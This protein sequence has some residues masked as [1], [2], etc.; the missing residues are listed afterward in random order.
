MR[1]SNEKIKNKISDYAIPFIPVLTT[2]VCMIIFWDSYYD[3]ND[4]TAIR[5]I[6][7]GTFSGTPSPMAVYVEY[8]LALLI[9][10]MYRIIP[11][12]PWFGMLEQTMLFGSM[13]LC[14]YSVSYKEKTKIGKIVYSILTTLFFDAFLLSGIVYIQYTTVAGILAAT[15]A[16]AFYFLEDKKEGKCFIKASIPCIV[17]EILAFCLRPNMMLIEIP[18]I[19]VAYLLKWIKGAKDEG[20]KCFAGKILFKYFV[21]LI[22]TVGLLIVTIVVNKIAYSSS[23]WKEYLEFNDNR[24]T[25]FDFQGYFPAYEDHKE[26]YDSIGW[27]EVDAQ[28]LLDYNIAIDDRINNDSLKKIVEYNE[29]EMG[30][31]YFKKDFVSALRDYKYKF[32]HQSE[33]KYAHVIIA[34]YVIAVVVGILTKDY[35]SMIATMGLFAAR[36]MGWMY[37]LMRERFPDRV[38]VPLCF[39]EAI[40]LFAFIICSLK[41]KESKTVNW[42]VAIII[43]AVSV[44]I[45]VNDI[46]K[47]REEKDKRENLNAE[48][49][50]LQ[51]YCEEHKD[52]YYVI[53][54]L[55]TVNYSEKIYEGREGDYANYEICGGWVA[56]NPVY[57]E[58]LAQRDIDSIAS[59]L[60]EDKAFFVTQDSKDVSWLEEYY[61]SKGISV[62]MIEEDTIKMGK[63]SAFMVYKVK[64][65]S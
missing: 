8:P 51:V 26:L 46:Q 54:V 3:I 12:V 55:S 30:F 17:C 2:I 34:L 1:N 49:K 48:W 28:I 53:D 23:E 9:S 36:S 62:I 5:N 40:I 19:G 61:N 64:E 37:L 60:I 21:P 59:A 35:A 52:G 58:K 18:M 43:A 24:T 15:G 32:F 7:S 39:C 31:G 4:D 56:N 20:E 42:L 13:Y 44:P 33:Y 47:T 57:K 38:L 65:N 41:K 16:V 6:L 25:L 29:N 27:D 14:A 22:I 45:L 11:N 63:D 50:S 10:V